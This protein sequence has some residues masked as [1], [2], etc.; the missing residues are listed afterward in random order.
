VVV[1]NVVVLEE[2]ET[3]LHSESLEITAV[4]EHV[5]TEPTVQ[6]DEADQE[7]E[8]PLEPT[9]TFSVDDG[10]V[11]KPVVDVVEE[12]VHMEAVESE[13][14]TAEEELMVEADEPNVGFSLGQANRSAVCDSKPRVFGLY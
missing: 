10:G 9:D 8:K 13:L 7:A 6:A 1:P 4:N 2:P 3:V 5:E 12:P 11:E 14:E